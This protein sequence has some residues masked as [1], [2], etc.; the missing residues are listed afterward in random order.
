VLSNFNDRWNLL[1]CLSISCQLARVVLFMVNYGLDWRVWWLNCG[2]RRD[3]RVV[4]VK[5]GVVV[6]FD[7]LSLFDELLVLL[8]NWLRFNYCN[9]WVLW[10]LWQLSLLFPQLPTSHDTLQWTNLKL[11]DSRTISIHIDPVPQHLPISIYL[12]NQL[13]RP[14]LTNNQFQRATLLSQQLPYN[15]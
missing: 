1:T 13:I 12:I 5:N 6:S 2:D 4:V 8:A 11:L 15:N 9:R 7:E 10:S 14:L 3:V